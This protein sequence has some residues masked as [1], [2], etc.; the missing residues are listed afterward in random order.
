[1]LDPLS[2]ASNS[3]DWSNYAPAMM[4]SGVIIGL[5]NRLRQTLGQQS[6]WGSLRS[7]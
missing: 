4:Y 7:N 1:M 5:L 2:S 6:G 3:L